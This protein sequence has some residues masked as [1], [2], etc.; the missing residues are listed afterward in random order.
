MNLGGGYNL[1]Q[2]MVIHKN[3]TLFCNKKKHTTTHATKWMNFKKKK[4]KRS[5]MRQPHILYEM[6]RKGKPIKKD[7]KLRVA[8]TEG[9][10]E[11]VK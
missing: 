8:G 9:G 5:Q 4:K 7:S 2:N 6:S 1:V 10:T 11:I 3:R